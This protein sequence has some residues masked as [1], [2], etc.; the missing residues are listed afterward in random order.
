MASAAHAEA[1]CLHVVVIVGFAAEAW[2]RKNKRM[3]TYKHIFVIV[4]SGCTVISRIGPNS[5]LKV[6][7]PT[8]LVKIS[9]FT[10]LLV[11]KLLV[12]SIIIT[13]DV[14]V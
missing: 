11:K 12:P 7:Y 10:Q 2:E 8:N 6:E 9:S 13:P 4:R 14:V 3:Q 5:L 1:S